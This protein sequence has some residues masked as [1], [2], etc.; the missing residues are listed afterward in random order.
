MAVELPRERTT[1]TQERHGSDIP[2]AG[3]SGRA[4]STKVCQTLCCTYRI[5]VF[6]RPETQDRKMNDVHFPQPLP[7]I[8]LCLVMI[9]SITKSHTFY[10]YSCR[11]LLPVILY[12]LLIS[13]NQT[14][15]PLTIMLSDSHSAPDFL[16]FPPD[17][18]R[19]CPTSAARIPPVGKPAS[20]D[21]PAVAFPYCP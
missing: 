2:S 10:E 1:E 3:R 16:A 14:T 8:S 18:R 12:F 17:H 6:V 20:P 5:L 19:P 11:N 13:A 9:T 4:L 7:A 15:A 21:L